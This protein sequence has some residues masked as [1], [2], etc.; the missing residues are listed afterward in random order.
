MA[1][2]NIYC[3][4]IWFVSFSGGKVLTE[5][6]IEPFFVDCSVYTK[7]LNASFDI[8]ASLGNVKACRNVSLK[9]QFYLVGSVSL[10]WIRSCVPEML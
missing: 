1:C 5:S 10:K 4:I 7:R 2:S 8:L 9:F 3:Q 6:E